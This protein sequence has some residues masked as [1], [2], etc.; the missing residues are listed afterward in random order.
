MKSSNA[1]A[2]LLGTMGVLVREESG[3][4]RVSYVGLTFE[5]VSAVVAPAGTQYVDAST[6]VAFA[7][8]TVLEERLGGGSGTGMQVLAGL[9]SRDK[10]VTPVFAP[11]S[12]EGGADAASSTAASWTEQTVQTWIMSSHMPQTSPRWLPL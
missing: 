6:R 4:Y 9:S 7:S 11:A 10:L 2:W 1:M 8:E 3:W 12:D 5:Q